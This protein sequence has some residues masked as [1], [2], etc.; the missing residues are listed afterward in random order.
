V[1]GHEVE[2]VY[3][4]FSATPH[5]YCNEPPTADCRQTTLDPDC[6][7]ESLVTQIRDLDGV[8]IGHLTPGGDEFHAQ[9]PGS[10]CSVV[11]WLENTEETLTG[12]DLVTPRIP[13]T[14][15]WE[16]DFYSWQA[17]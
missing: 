7:C 17:A 12:P 13:I 15:R 4:G 11:V 14:F 2:L 1:A 9:G 8:V 10:E 5:F 16:G 6:W 3:N